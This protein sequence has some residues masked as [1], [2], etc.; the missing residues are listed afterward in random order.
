MKPLTRIRETVR[1]RHLEK[2]RYGLVCWLKNLPP[3]TRSCLAES[4]LSL[5]DI[6]SVIHAEMTMASILKLMDLLLLLQITPTQAA[7][8]QTHYLSSP[9]HLF[10]RTDYVNFIPYSHSQSFTH[11]LT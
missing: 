3:V 8:L 7:P 2:S 11:R 4:R 1:R 10:K 6:R 5:I 9:H